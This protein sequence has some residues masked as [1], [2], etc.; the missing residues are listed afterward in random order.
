MEIIIKDIFGNIKDLK[1]NCLKTIKQLEKAHVLS[2]ML[3]DLA[4]C[5]KLNQAVSLSHRMIGVLLNRKGE[6]TWVIVGDANRLYLPDIGRIRGAKDR[7]RGLRL[8]VSSPSPLNLSKN[9]GASYA[10]HKDFI[11]DLEKLRLDAVI[12]IDASKFN[13]EGPVVVANLFNERQ[14]NGDYLLVSQEKSYKNINAIPQNFSNFLQAILDSLKTSESSLRDINIKD[15]AFLVGIY[16]LKKEGYRSMAELK[17]LARS[18]NVFVAEEKIQWR[19]NLDPKTVIGRNTLEN[20]CLEAL[21]KNI[22]IIIF[23]RELSPS[24]L[25]HITDLTDLKILDRPMLILDIFAQRAVTQEGK[26][27]VE[28]AQLTYS[29]P[30]LAKKQSGLSRLTG[31]IGGRG[32]G[33]TKLEVNKR[34]IKDKLAR[35]EK[36]LDKIKDQRSLRRKNR[37]N[38]QLPTLA[39]VGYTNAGKSTLINKLCGSSIYAKDEL[40]ATL[41]PHSRRLRFPSEQEVIITDTVGFIHNLPKALL[42]AFM[43]TLEELN[44]ADILL[45]VVDSTDENY[46]K[47]IDVVEQILKELELLDKP[48]IMIFNKIDGL[49][50]EALSGFYTKFSD[51]VFISATKNL[52]L[53]DLINACINKIAN[54]NISLN[55]EFNEKE[56]EEVFFDERDI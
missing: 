23:D 48:R 45:H 54:L 8:V 19:R 28:V 6:V 50:N 52:G 7:L 35:L 38:N 53:S 13:S 25:M 1:A 36:T 49:E 9:K 42:K 43:A 15:R 55:Y 22:E 16:S 3:V 26:I 29:L 44:Y 37:Q 41:D 5:R 56:F 4:L 17:E 24:Q 32:P 20:I 12:E 33:E 31:G 18:A 47:H 10:V 46:L 51:A 39:I 2:D 34:I 30:R 14:E 40:F 27:Q 21:A 11:T